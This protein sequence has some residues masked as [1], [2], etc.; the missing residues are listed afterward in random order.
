M[1]TRWMLYLEQGQELRLLRGVPR[2]WLTPGEAIRVR[3]VWSYFGPISFDMTIDNTGRRIDVDIR[4]DDPTRRPSLIK[5]RLPHPDG[6]RAI[7]A[8]A[9]EY[10][11]ANETVIMTPTPATLGSR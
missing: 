10:D 6:L 2:V 1:Q 11:A 3:D 4:C 8:T 5:V 7:E 9:G